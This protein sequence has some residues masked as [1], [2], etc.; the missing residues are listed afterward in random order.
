[1]SP[2]NLDGKGSIVEAYWFW[3]FREMRD[4]F[5]EFLP[6]RPYMIVPWSDNILTLTFNGIALT[7]CI[8]TERSDWNGEYRRESCLRNGAAFKNHRQLFLSASPLI[9]TPQRYSLV[10]FGCRVARLLTVCSAKISHGAL[11]NRI[12]GPSFPFFLLSREGTF[13]AGYRMNTHFGS[14]AT[15][16]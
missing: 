5:P 16:I 1:M 15:R 14:R 6:G 7:A 13:G 12:S 2:L 4:N 3:A 9:Q 8:R 11:R 10:H